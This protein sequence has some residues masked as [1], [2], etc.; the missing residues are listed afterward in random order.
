VAIWQRP[1][2]ESRAN[3][4]ANRLAQ[5][6]HVSDQEGPFHREKCGPSIAAMFQ[7]LKSE[8]FPARDDF[9]NQYG[10]STSGLSC[11]PWTRMLRGRRSE[12]TRYQPVDPSFFREAIA[13]IPRHTFVDLGCGRG[14]ALILAHFSGFRKL[15]GVEFSGALCR[16]A[17][18]NLRTLRIKGDVVNGDAGRYR[19]PDEPTVVY[20][21]NPFGELI[22]RQV[23]SNFGDQPRLVVYVNPVH[24]SPFESLRLVRSGRSFKIFSNA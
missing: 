10:V 24:V 21:Y 17:R 12:T 1:G 23:L 4:K 20:L 13:D 11:L 14:R 15:V 19:L 3:S 8:L 7:R 2:H 9:D 16:S 6:G 5:S 22:M 18:K